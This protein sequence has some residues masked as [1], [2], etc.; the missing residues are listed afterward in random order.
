MTKKDQVQGKF[1]DL[2]DNLD[3]LDDLPCT[4]LDSTKTIEVIVETLYEKNSSQAET[5]IY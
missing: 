2:V 3:Y 5:R 1:E 4:T